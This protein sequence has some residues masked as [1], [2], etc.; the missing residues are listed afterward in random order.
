MEGEKKQITTT[1]KQAKGNSN[2]IQGNEGQDSKK[3]RD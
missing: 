3:T 2:C 1:N